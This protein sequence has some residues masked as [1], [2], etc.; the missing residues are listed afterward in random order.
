VKYRLDEVLI[1][2][3]VVVTCS[4]DHPDGMNFAQAQR[5]AMEIVERELR[6]LRAYLEKIKTL[7]P[8]QVD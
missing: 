3:P 6:F 2:R 5:A 8:D 4:L 7:T 1:L